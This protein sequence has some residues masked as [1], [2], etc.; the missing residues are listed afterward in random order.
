MPN[1]ALAKVPRYPNTYAKDFM[2]DAPWRV[3]GVSTII[4][5]GFFIKDSDVNDL[6]DL[7]SAEIYL[8]RNGSKERIYRHNFGGIKLGQFF[9]EWVATEF[10]N[11]PA[12]SKDSVL[13]GLKNGNSIITDG[14]VVLIGID[15]NGDGKLDKGDGDSIV[16]DIALME[17][18]VEILISWIAYN[19]VGINSIKLF[20]G[21]NLIH[22]FNPANDSSLSGNDR[23]G[24]KVFEFIPD[25]DRMNQYLRAECVT[26]VFIN[27]SGFTDRYRAYTNPL[28]FTFPSRHS[29]DYNPQD[30]EIS[31]SELLRVI[32]LYNQGDYHCDPGGEDGYA[33][34]KGDDTCTPTVRTTIPRIGISL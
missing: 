34:A 19:D 2:A 12:H 30:Y 21:K 4:P 31:L 26:Q 15:K 29:S 23:E 20:S 18:K 3:K 17:D 24:Y 14:P 22:E 6:P 25:S 13:E 33:P 10:E 11:A 27:S 28:Y 1:F 5:V 7:D 32:Q 9:W 16:G 8:L